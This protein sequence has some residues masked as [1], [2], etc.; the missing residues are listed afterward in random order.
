MFKKFHCPSIT[1]TRIFLAS[2]T[3]AFVSMPVTLHAAETAA[4]NDTIDEVVV[5]AIR[6][7]AAL[8][9]TGSSIWVVDEELIES[10]GYLHMTDALVSVPGL[11]VNQNGP[12]GGQAA[13]RIRGASSDQTLVLLDG[14]LL[15][16][17]S[18]PGGGFNFG[19]IDVSDVARI[20]VLKGPQSTLW[21]SNAIGGVINIVSKKPSEELSA[22]FGITTG[23][24]GT[25]RYRGS[26]SAGNEVADFRISYNDISTDGI[27]KA[28]EKD[29]NTEDDGFDSQTLSLKASVI[30]PMDARLQVSHRT[31]DADTEF[32]SFGPATGVQDGDEL[33]RTE[34]SSTLLTLTLPE[35]DDRLNNTLKYS[36]TEIVRNNFSNGAASFG[37]IGER[38]VLQ[39]QGTFTINDAHQVSVGYEDE[40]TFDGTTEFS[41]TGIYAL[42]R[43]NPIDNLTVSLGIRRDDNNQY[44]SEVVKSVNAILAVNENIDLRASWGEGFKVPTI[45]QTTFFCCGATGPNT[46]LEAEKSDAFDFGVDWR[47]M[48]N[49]GLVSV[50]FFSQDT[51]NQIDFSFG[52]G[53]YENIAQVDSKGVELALAYQFTDSLSTAASF[54]YIDSKDGTGQALSRLPKLTGDLSLNWQPLPK[55]NTSLVVVYNDEEEDSRGVVSDWA[56][57]DMSAV[58]H[59]SDE[60]RITARIE[61][62]ADKDYQQ[63]FGYGTPERSGYVDVTYT[64]L[65]Q[66]DE[67]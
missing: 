20:E 39:Y 53:G 32:D 14:I 23:S 6:L 36:N 21:G 7:P 16:D 48:D 4:N 18:S 40:E 22:N 26:V 28:D 60:F 42:Y 59:F 1:A 66:S 56:R 65:G 64:F 11:T 52:V 24:F 47:F 2:L 30:L 13:A 17:V 27:S 58:Y 19:A 41:N 10:R 49:N 8:A 37:A 67:K 51:E 29:G 55:L 15:N 3:C 62:L 38:N 43:V 57:V 12:F 33:S 9:E 63:I 25:L 50:T 5:Q 34:Q 61:N 44:G 54:A 35:F 46:A 31:T 45:F